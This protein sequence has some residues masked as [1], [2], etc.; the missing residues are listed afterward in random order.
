MGRVKLRHPAPQELTT[1]RLLLSILAP[2]VKVTRLIGTPGGVIALT[3][4]EEDVEAIF[5]PAILP[6]LTAASFQPALPP[7]LRARRTVICSRLD[8]LVCGYTTQEYAEEIHRLQDWATVV[9]TFKFPRSN[10]LKLVFS[11]SDMARRALSGGLRLFGMSVPPGQIRQETYIPLVACDRCHK[12]EHHL[13]KE[14]PEPHDYQL[15]SE[16]GGNDHTF[17]ACSAAQKSCPNCKEQHSARAMRCPVRK[18][19][20]K[21]KEAQARQAPRPPSYALAA[22]ATTT[23]TGPTAAAPVSPP[24][25]DTGVLSSKGVMILLHA[26]MMNAAHP[27]TFGRWLSEGL[28]QNGME[29]MKLPGNPPSVQILRALFGTDD[30]QTAVAMAAQAANVPNAPPPVDA[31]ITSAPS[32]TS[33][34]RDPSPVVTRPATLTVPE[35]STPPTASPPSSPT[36]LNPKDTTSLRFSPAKSSTDPAPTVANDDAKDDIL[37]SIV[38]KSSVK[39]PRERSYTSISSVLNKPGYDIFH[40]GKP[41]DRQTILTFL[42][43]KTGSLASLCLSLEDEVFE[44]IAARSP[45][46]IDERLIYRGN[47]LRT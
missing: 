27:G 8:D 35:G 34:Q 33:R 25:G 31:S 18:A 1:R 6:K 32:T 21:E 4:A 15:C 37:F 42:S 39:W 12:V 43:Q 45:P 30:H 46:Q 28:A 10:T 26:H 47:I 17:R 20:V 40:A 2:T 16:C 14:C 7:E 38:K 3:A 9:D 24:Q 29:P 23:T 5:S 22:A 44:D 19:A 11:S 36:P 41:T 13:T